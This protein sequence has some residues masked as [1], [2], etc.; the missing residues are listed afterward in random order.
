[1]KKVLFI[2]IISLVMLLWLTS[3]AGTGDWTYRLP[4][5]YEVWH[6]NSGEILIKSVNLENSGEKIPSFVKEFSY[7]E[8]YVFSRNVEEIS[9]N[10]I[11][12]E[13]YYALDTQEKKVYG[14]F[15]N[16]YE[17]QKQAE[18]WGGKLPEKWY[19]TSP[20]PNISK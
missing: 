10:N 5:D 18:E 15:E 6:V 12:D 16:I 1:M 13:I 11:F 19:R 2:F 8:R 20:D 17:L 14:P 4:N 3:C 7:N 9:K